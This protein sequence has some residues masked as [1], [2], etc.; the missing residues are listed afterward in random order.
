MLQSI[1]NRLIRFMI[2]RYG[3]DQLY[4]AGLFLAL[5]IMI[6]NMAVNSSILMWVSYLVLFVNIARS[7][8][9]NIAKRRKENEFF[10]KFWNPVR[11]ETKFFFRRIKEFR[12]ARYKTCPH[13]KKKLKLPVK[14][15]KNTVNC[16]N[17]HETFNVRTFL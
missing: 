3:I 7:F 9:R 6:I 16:P 17:C 14:R 4:Y 11:K 2:G 13:C 5:G 1:K 8:S 15:G 10:L 12:T